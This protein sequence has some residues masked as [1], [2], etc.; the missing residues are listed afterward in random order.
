MNDT[1]APSLSTSSPGPVGSL[2]QPSEQDVALRTTQLAEQSLSDSELR[3]EVLCALFKSLLEQTHNHDAM[4]MAVERTCDLMRT[5]ATESKTK[6]V[7]MHLIKA[8]RRRSSPI[9]LL[10]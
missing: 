2:P 6:A 10:F 4:Y 9:D 1:N 8:A 5:H 7:C 3:L